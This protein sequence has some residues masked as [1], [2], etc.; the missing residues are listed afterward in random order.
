MRGHPDLRLLIWGAL[1]CAIAALLA[2]WGA[3][4]LLFAAPLT[5]AM[6]GYAIVSAAFARHP[7]DRARLAVLSIALSLAI[8]ALG[9]VVLNYTP[10][11]IHGISWAALLLIVI[12]GCAR[13]AALR[14]D[15]EPVAPSWPRIRLSHLEWGMGLG[16]LAAVVAA[17]VLASTTLP[18]KDA[19]GFTELWIVPVAES[20]GSKARIGVRSQEQQATEFDMGIRIGRDRVVRRSFTLAPGEEEVVSVGAAPGPAGTEVPVVATLLLDE[21]PSTVYRRVRGSLTATGER[22]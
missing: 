13:A 19:L 5:L 11:G 10:G 16:A 9:S 7:L 4:S 22:P 15:G 21:D 3:V 14:R 12:F 1:L 6:P 20:G 18:A 2:P 8:L 17:L